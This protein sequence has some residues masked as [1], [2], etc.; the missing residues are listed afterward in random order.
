MLLNKA[1]LLTPGPTPLPEEV[2]LALSR[3]MIH[4][5]EQGFCELVRKCQ[6]QLQ[7]LFGTKEPVLCLSSSGTGAMCAAVD[8]LFAP[9]DKVLVVNAGKF[10]ERWGKIAAKNGLQV[11]ELNYE[12]GLA[13]NPEDVEAALAD[14]RDAKGLLIQLSETSTGVL[15]PIREIAEKVKGT[16]VLLVVDGIS[17][18]GVSPCP[19]DE[20]GI[21]CLVTG[22]QKGL[23]L[24]PGL[25]FI[26]LSQRAWA[27]CGDGSFYFNLKKEREKLAQGQT[28]FTSPVNLM[29]GLSAALDLLLSEGLDALYRKQWALTQLCRRSVEAM[30]LT[31][32]AR[33][34]YAWGLTS[35]LL[36]DA[37]AGSRVIADCHEK[38]GVTI[39]GG[40]DTLKGRIVRL[41]HMGW[42]DWAD[43]TAGLYALNRAIVDNGGFSGSHDFLEQGL[44]SYRAALEGEIGVEP[45]P[46]H[47]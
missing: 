22:S 12:W 6:E 34:N 33:T 36:P 16:G 9:G 35:V 24:P 5:R 41:A 37:V 29:V 43:V 39:S 8:N 11:I 31:P 15:H 42:I 18:V 47:N 13:A 4:H 25:S 28:S 10:G 26:A 32:L 19:M 2:R 45:K 14:N 1:R 17:G 23:M 44:A 46:L 40:Q 7:I 27:A 38:Y 21:D 30:G 20:W 3:D